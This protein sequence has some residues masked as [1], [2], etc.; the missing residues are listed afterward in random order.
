MTPEKAA[1]WGTVA[2]GLITIVGTILIGILNAWLQ[3]RQVE[4]QL[5]KE[6]KKELHQ[7]RIAAL[8][9]C[10]QMVDFL[11]GASHARN[12]GIGYNDTAAREIW[13]RIR[14]ENVCNGAFFPPDLQ[15]DFARVIRWAALLEFRL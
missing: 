10:V 9:N 7:K 2:G 8:Q 15:D 1:L 6:S 3:K 4:W 11:I 5:K 12:S 14:N 13:A